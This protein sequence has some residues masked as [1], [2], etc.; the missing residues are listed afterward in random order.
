MRYPE[1]DVGL[2]SGQGYMVE[3]TTYCKHLASTGDVKQVLELNNVFHLE[4]LELTQ[5]NR[6]QQSVII[7]GQSALPIQIERTLMQLG[8]EQ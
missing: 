5:F 3:D 4:I 2:T 1:N 7:I 8:W 6:G